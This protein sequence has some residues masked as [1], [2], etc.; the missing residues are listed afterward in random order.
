[1]CAD[2]AIFDPDVFAERGTTF[3]PNR[4]AGGMV[5]VLV[6]GKPVVENGELTGNR[7]GQV[8]RRS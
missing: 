8:L 6:N 3:E 2:V 1:M 5:H 4:T 7:S